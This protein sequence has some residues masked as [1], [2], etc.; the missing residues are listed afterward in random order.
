MAF[1]KTGLDAAICW[2]VMLA[3]H[4]R[5]MNIIDLM[6]VCNYTVRF[7]GSYSTPLVGPTVSEAESTYVLTYD[8]MNFD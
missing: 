7:I 8:S 6:Y 2:P 3:R 5:S 1:M 4:Y